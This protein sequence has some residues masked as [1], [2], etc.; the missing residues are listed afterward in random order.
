MNKLKKI[1]D[2][3]A[4]F[5]LAF[6]C[7]GLLFVAKPTTWMPTLVIVIGG[8]LAA[9]NSEYRSRFVALFGHA[10]FKWIAWSFVAWLCVSLMVSTV[11]MEWPKFHVPSNEL[12]FVL[13]LSI[14]CLFV[15]K[16]TKQ[17]FYVGLMAGA[18]ASAMWGIYELW[19]LGLGRALGT[20]NNP[21]HFGNLTALIALLSFS[22]AL[23][24]TTIGTKLRGALLFSAAV[25]VFASITSLTRSSAILVLCAIP[26]IWLP[27]RDPLR[28][29]AIKTAGLLLVVVVCAIGFSAQVRER[30]RIHE[31]TA[32]FNNPEKIDYERLTS[33]RANMWHAATLVFKE[34]PW[35]GVGP[36][37]FS[38]AFEALAVE[39]AVQKTRFHNQP[40]NDILYSASM[41]GVFKLLAYLALIFAPFIFFY[42][43]YQ[44]KVELTSKVPSILGMQVIAT[45]FLTGLTNSNFDLQIYSTMYAVLVCVL[46]R[47][48]VFEINAAAPSTPLAQASSNN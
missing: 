24:D 46:A 16:A 44:A 13:A 32:A 33:D 22:A 2:E 5:A 30:L 25:A 27:Q 34:R 48:S 11:H 28:R 36:K 39:G 40:H 23:V 7:F 38:D 6:G 47:L 12:R 31:F 1:F 18:C 9:F 21:I 19:V 29:F 8:G 3:W 4:L 14:L 20:T 35:A 17:A 43:S 37:G 26:L 10:Q 45:F 15:Q 42:R 41:G